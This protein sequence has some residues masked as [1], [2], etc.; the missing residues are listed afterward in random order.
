MHIIDYT[1]RTDEMEVFSMDSNELFWVLGYIYYARH[2]SNC[3]AN[4]SCLRNS[5]NWNCGSLRN[6]LLFNEVL[7][8]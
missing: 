6:V 1:E 2:Y 4:C 8:H 7:H 5:F 3:S